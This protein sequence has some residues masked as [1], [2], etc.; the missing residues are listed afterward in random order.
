MVQ[1]NYL[2]SFVFL[3]MWVVV[4]GKIEIVFDE[5][6]EV[7]GKGRNFDLSQLDFIPFNDTHT[8]LNG[9]YHHFCY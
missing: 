8:V 6:M 4:Y 5:G 1:L 3:S 9:N 2:L 7:C